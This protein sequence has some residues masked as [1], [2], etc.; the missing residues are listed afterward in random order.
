M[1]IIEENSAAD[2]QTE[3]A[4][5]PPS[6][7][8]AWQ[9]WVQQLKT[10]DRASISATV[11]LSAAHP[12]GLAQLYAGRPT[13][14]S[15]LV[16]EPHALA[17]ARARA[18]DLLASQSA[19]LGQHGAA[20][21]HLAV[22]SASW[23]HEGERTL[24]TPA[25]LRPLSMRVSEDEDIVVQ[26][27]PGIM[28]APELARALAEVGHQVNLVEKQPT[29][30]SPAA[31]FQS[32]RRLGAQ[33]LNG[34][35]L[36]ESLTIGNFISPRDILAA[37]YE[38]LAYRAGMSPIIRALAGSESA[39]K[40][41][42]EPLPGKVPTDRDPNAE[43]GVGDLDPAGQDVLDSVAL[44]RSIFLDTPPSSGDT[45]TIAA[46]L[47]DAAS[48]GKSVMYVP[49][50]RRAALALKSYLEQLGL[51]QF[52]LDL[53]DNTA[54][55][56]KNIEQLRAAFT[57][58]P[59][60]V[61]SP[62]R[63]GQIRA[64]LRSAREKL[65]GYTDSL[66]RPEDE[67]GI[68]PYDALQ[69]LT[70]LTATSDGPRTRV[71]FSKE[72]LDQIASDGAETARAVL[73]DAAALGLFQNARQANPWQ[74]VV[75]SA[76]EAV[77]TTL[78]AVQELSLRVLPVARA[79]IIRV[80]GETGLPA[81]RTIAEWEEQLVMLGGVREVLDVFRPQV[82]ERSAAD[83]VI[84]TAPKA[85]RA[86]RALNM[87]GSERRRLVRQA[88]YLLRPGVKVEDLHAELVRVQE[89]RALWVGY[90]DMAGW[91]T[92]P[93]GLDEAIGNL[94]RV[95]EC[96]EAIQP[97]FATAHG[98]LKKLPID[99]LTRL[100]D[101][102]AQDKEGAR[103]LPG[104]V[105]ALRSL[106]ELGLEELGNDLRERQVPESLIGPELDLAW[107]ASALSY[108]LSKD[109]RLAHYTGETLSTLQMQLRALDREQVTS[110]VPQARYQMGTQVRRSLLQEREQ[111]TMLFDALSPGKGYS[112]KQIFADFPVSLRVVPI[113][114]VP[115]VQ[116]SQLLDH[117]AS[118]DLVV[119]HG[120]EAFTTSE[121]LP[122]LVRGRQAVV[123]GDARR[124]REGALAD[125]AAILPRLITPPARVRVNE[126]ISEF[127]AAHGYG[128][129]VLSVPA[130]RAS[131][132]LSLKTVDGRGMPAP[133]TTSVETSN[134]EIEAVVGEVIDHALIHP[135]QSLAV[136]A[137]NKRHAAR[138]SEAILAAVAN[139]PAVD[140]F[141][142]KTKP[143]PFVV[144]PV[145]DVAGIQR[146]RCIISV[147]YA[148]TPHGRLLH[149]FG[150]IGGPQGSS[151]LVDALTAV[152]SDL[153]IVASFTAEDVDRSRFATEGAQMLLDLLQA[154]R[155]SALELTPI[156]KAQ[157]ST[158][159]E[160]APDRLLVDLAERLYRLGLTVIPNVGT[161]QGMRIPLAIGHPHLPDELL[162]AVLT[163]NQDYVAEQS[164]R[165]RE[166]HW[167]S[168]LSA[169][170]WAVY[171][172][173]STAVFMN[174]QAEAEAILDLVLDTVE[175]L[176]QDQTCTSDTSAVEATTA[177]VEIG[178]NSE[179]D[180]TEPVLS[181]AV[182]RTQMR[183]PVVPGLPLSAYGDDQLDALAKWIVSDGQERD[184]EQLAQELAEQLQITR[185]GAGVEA[186]L[187]NVARR[188]LA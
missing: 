131:G 58:E 99:A 57:A 50:E 87:K 121:L 15:N 137:L 37:D 172:V 16:R 117:N 145:T 6:F 108:M 134:D 151:M 18:R 21:L 3:V 14:L 23:E 144:V 185:W 95:L 102:L 132:S 161:A 36:Y 75:I 98:D 27:H 67:W 180:V 170:G 73:Y 120:V 29:D 118:V 113:L 32:I 181:P 133:G 139:A 31:H 153:L 38:K 116:V 4:G 119:F 7:A 13:R 105:R 8:S 74:G 47:V 79:E 70:D 122:A 178:D 54:W 174:P 158:E 140:S 166:R 56:D 101:S 25:L 62:D 169:A 76:A 85:W 81:A 46:V 163:D 184:R 150:L 114:V 55:N 107:W 52:L 129:D 143:E 1:S 110:L 104:R 146:D 152:R 59:V 61:D 182:E 96:L 167:P 92:L 91:P 84:A 177:T 164:L 42:A 44:G 155:Q 49:G 22:G 126:H 183:P 147:G 109:E 106:Q 10:A 20:P 72:R 28:C 111:A 60:P 112:L 141:F 69:V 186:V 100:V 97:Y 128:E 11:E 187:G 123:A 26:L 30:F 94:D 78:E 148:K 138:L 80:A 179:D 41:L 160:V 77:D 154:A 39:V 136:I 86:E 162:V 159:E 35:D 93:G 82:F 130:P 115:P 127:L 48:S 5:S 175:R 33:T 24:P 68:S 135:E 66:H 90:G 165:R 65:G 63:V 168:M 103:E 45:E 53:S 171:M 156:Q 71:R 88:R 149:D 34:F 19:L 9:Q 188:N 124:L 12:T 40:E 17:H 142:D 89:Y 43:R 176:E 157:Q 2:G 173:Y 125:F 51:S 64:D 83:M